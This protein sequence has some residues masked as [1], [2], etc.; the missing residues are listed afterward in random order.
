MTVPDRL[1]LLGLS[2]TDTIQELQQRY[3]KGK[4]HAEAL[5]REVFKK[6]NR[7]VASAPEFSASPGLT[8]RLVRDL[9][10]S[11]GRIG[12][13]TE[14][15]GPLKFISVLDD[16]LEIES[17]LVPMGSYNTLCISSQVGCR[18]G[19]SFCE[20]GRMGLVRNL[21]AEEIV[22]QILTARFTL[23]IPVRNIVFMGMGEP[24]DNQD[25]VFQAIRVMTEQ[26]GLDI[27]MSQITL[28][29]AGRVDGL[30]RLGSM[31]WSGLRI[32]I[33][34]NA[35]NNALRSTLMPVNRAYPL[36]VLKRA[37]LSYPLAAGG[38]FLFEYV[39]IPGTNDDATHAREIG[40]YLSGLRARVNLIGY[41]PGRED[42]SGAPEDE[43]LH[44]FA[45]LLRAQG[46]PVRIRWSKGRA[47]MAGCG[48]LCATKNV[49]TD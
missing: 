46:I 40:V 5:Y 17:V 30:L 33:S 13:C 22:G 42:T 28:S 23:Q 10:L 6:G 8:K 39:L 47:I 37:L 2:L 18:M 25:E 45:A 20:T 38:F 11:F 1:P 35:A 43:E 3:A 14:Q 9:S 7:D 29:T 15:S 16:G 12:P 49:P 48:Q 34:L 27:A 44:R 41:N 24:L 4:Y 26:K 36:T 21:R 19:C 31:G 32:A